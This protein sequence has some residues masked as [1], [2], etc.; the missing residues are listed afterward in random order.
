M[1]RKLAWRFRKGSEADPFNFKPCGCKFYVYDKTVVRH[2]EEHRL[3]SEGEI[4]FE[5][6]QPYPDQP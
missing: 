6:K 2:C 1:K 5:D 4:Y 3:K